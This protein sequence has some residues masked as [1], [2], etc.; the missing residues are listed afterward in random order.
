MPARVATANL[1]PMAQDPAQQTRDLIK[2]L[3][4]HGH[5][6]E[7]EHLNC[8]L[9]L[10][11]VERGLLFA[12]REAC[13]TVLTAIEAVDPVTQT[14][15]EELRLDVEVRLRLPDHGKDARR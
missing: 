5:H 15:I 7:A 13:E 9:S 2:R 14:M 12:L 1:Q 6:A 8:Q 4:E 11:A 10:H 3:H